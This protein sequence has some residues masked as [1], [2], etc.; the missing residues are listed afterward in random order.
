MKRYLVLEDGSIFEGTAIG[1]DEFKTGEL[2]FTNAMSGYQE[3]LTDSAYCGQIVVCTYPMIGNVGINRDDFESMIPTLY[4]LVVSECCEAGSNFRCDQSLN[5]FMKQ[6]QI[7]G[8]AGVDTRSIVRKI[9]DEGVMKAVFCD[10]ESQLTACVDR[11]KHTEE[12]KR[13]SV[14]VTTPRPFPIPNRGQKLILVD[15]G[16]KYGVIRE[17]SERDCDVLVVPCTSSIEE[18]MASRPEGIVLSSGPGNPADCTEAIEMI[19]A[20]QDTP[21]LGIGLGAEVMALAA[22]M[23]VKKMKTGHHGSSIPVRNLKDGRIQFTSQNHG[24]EIDKEVPADCEITYTALNDGSVE[25]F[26]YK[27]QMGVCFNLEGA[28]G[29]SE[30]S[31]VFDEFLNLLKERGIKNA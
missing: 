26:K 9:R 21:M 23:K 13:L 20:C 16:C 1:S 2:I 18:I 17:L 4:G 31:D 29:N 15:F 30:C 11:L 27:Q 8:I 25:G 19:K 22:G 24:Y 28:P 7:P 3:M 6:K 12:E 5:E 10:D 14:K